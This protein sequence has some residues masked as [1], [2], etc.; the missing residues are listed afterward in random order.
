MIMVEWKLPTVWCRSCGLCFAWSVCS[1]LESVGTVTLTVRRTGNVHCKCFVKYAT[2]DGTAEAGQ[3]Y[4]ATSGELT[5]AVG[6]ATADI[7]V[8][9]LDDNLFEQNEHFEVEPAE[10]GL[11]RRLGHH[12]G[13][14]PHDPRTTLT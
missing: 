12:V 3:D 8:G 2:V 9:I 6:Q 5:F 11:A 13:G 10:L 1:Q 7:Q 4:V 14:K